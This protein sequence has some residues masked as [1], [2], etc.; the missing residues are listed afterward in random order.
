[1]GV[2]AER[3]ETG[4]SWL[5]ERSGERLDEDIHRFLIL[6]DHG[7]LEAVLG[8]L[9]KMRDKYREIFGLDPAIKF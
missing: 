3:R 9:V 6:A 5:I 1:M 4:M 8:G 2:E 7:H